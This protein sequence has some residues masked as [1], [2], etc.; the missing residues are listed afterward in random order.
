MMGLQ[1]TVSVINCHL[2]K[3]AGLHILTCFLVEVVLVF[4]L[5]FPRFEIRNLTQSTNQI[6]M[7][8][9]TN[10]VPPKS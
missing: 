7:L 5:I 8:E 6:T 2:T 3:H 4:S 1:A 10:P 9:E